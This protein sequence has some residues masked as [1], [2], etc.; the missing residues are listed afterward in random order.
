M[1]ELHNLE[2]HDLVV[3][4]DIALVGRGNVGENLRVLNEETGD[5]RARLGDHHAS[6][7]G[8]GQ[9]LHEAEQGLLALQRLGLTARLERL[10]FVPPPTPQSQS[11]FQWSN[12]WKWAILLP[13]TR[14]A[15]IALTG[16]QLGLVIA[17][18]LGQLWWGWWGVLGTVVGGFLLH[19][20]AFKVYAKYVAGVPTMDDDDI[21]G[22]THKADYTY[23]RWIGP[24]A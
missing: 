3:Q 11:V 7:E 10:E 9:R 12:L 13:G 17:P 19:E 16:W 23:E 18:A 1:S 14:R 4:R 22:T 24:V 2:V 20:V 15:R 8:L 21:V 6:I 5:H